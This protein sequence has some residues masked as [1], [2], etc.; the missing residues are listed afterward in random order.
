MIYGIPKEGF[1]RLYPA[2]EEDICLYPS[3][4]VS[5]NTI[6][7]ERAELYYRVFY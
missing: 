3:E 6:E 1:Y 4:E 5:F 7:D 2:F